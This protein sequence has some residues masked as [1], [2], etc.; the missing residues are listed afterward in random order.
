[1][2]TVF[3][4][5]VVP[6]FAIEISSEPSPSSGVNVKLP[7]ESAATL[8]LASSS[9]TLKSSCCEPSPSA[10]DTLVPSVNEIFC[11]EGLN[12]IVPPVTLSC[13]PKI[14]APFL[15]ME[16]FSAPSS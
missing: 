5:I 4:K 9:T 8:K 12:E 13:P 2:L 16:K 3:L 10:S 1:M 14:V 7:S 6:L 15:L 11:V